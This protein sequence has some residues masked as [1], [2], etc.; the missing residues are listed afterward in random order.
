MPI[1]RVAR[2]LDE[3]TSAS[4]ARA[5]RPRASAGSAHIYGNVYMRVDVAHALA[6]SS[7]F[8]LLGEQSSSKCVIPCLGGR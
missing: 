3:S 2:A 1:L 5:T 7:D 6:D 4:S 8:G